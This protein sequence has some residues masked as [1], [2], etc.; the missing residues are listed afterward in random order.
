M[1]SLYKEDYQKG[2]QKLM[3]KFNKK[4]TFVVAVN[5]LVGLRMSSILQDK[6]N[7]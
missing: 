2:K 4:R 3:R 7:G 6:R 1:N 5:L